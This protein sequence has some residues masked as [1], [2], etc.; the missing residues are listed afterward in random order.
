MTDLT[1]RTSTVTAVA[2]G[3]DAWLHVLHTYFLNSWN[4]TT[5]GLTAPTAVS[6]LWAT[7]LNQKGEPVPALSVE[8][9][10][11]AWA[12]TQRGIANTAPVTFGPYA[13][14]P[15]VGVVLHR[16]RTDDELDEK[17][18]TED[19]T[20]VIVYLPA[21]VDASTGLSFA[22]GALQINRTA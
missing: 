4:G 12:T 15:V 8:I 9:D 18:P 3:V 11:G 2:L 6:A 7:P 17:V 20:V 1:E 16:P 13:T 10:Y 19:D 14:L 5:R 21:P 22:V